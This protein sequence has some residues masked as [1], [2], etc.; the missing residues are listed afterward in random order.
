MRFAVQDGLL[1]APRSKV[2][3][4]QN[5]EGNIVMTLSSG[6]FL[7]Q[8]FSTEWIFRVISV[9]IGQ[10]GELIYLGTSKLFTTLQAFSKLSVSEPSEYPS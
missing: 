8:R 7:V 5:S 4:C 3:L 9:P 10:E 6:V 1:S 2:R